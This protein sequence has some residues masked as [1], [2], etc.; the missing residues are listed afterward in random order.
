MNVKERRLIVRT[1]C[2]ILV[3]GVAVWMYFLG[4]Q[5]TVLVDN[6]AVE[7]AAGTIQALSVVEVRVDGQKDIELYPRDRDQFI[8]TGQ[9]HTITMKFADSSYNDV[10]IVR[11]FS[12]PLEQDMVL[13]SLPLLADS[14]DAD[15]SVWLSPFE[16]LVTPAAPAAAE[17]EIVI[18][19]DILLLEGF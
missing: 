4:R 5:H 14:P 18:E 12:I 3:I 13:I 7:Q 10:E 2:V 17:E 19:E 6:R 8:V 11:S 1:G 15:Q 16:P 9:R